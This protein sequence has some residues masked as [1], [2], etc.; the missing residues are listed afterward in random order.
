LGGNA[1]TLTDVLV[2]ISTG[3]IGSLFYRYTEQ[4][5]CLPAIFLGT[6]YWFFYGTAF[7]I[8][9]LEIIGGELQTGVIRFM[10]VSVKTY[11]LALGSTFGMKMVL[12][13][14]LGAWQQSGYCSTLD[15]NEKW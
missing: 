12:V 2:G 6:L 11:V 8:G 14:S 15:L 9:I 4:Q 3:I 13:D 1:K 5:T 7:V 10:A